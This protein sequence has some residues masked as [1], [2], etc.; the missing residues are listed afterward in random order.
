[1]AISNVGRVISASV[2]FLL[3]LP[4]MHF[5]KKDVNFARRPISE[6]CQLKYLSSLP[7]FIIYFKQMQK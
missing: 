4:L 5:Y 6:F 1:M 3:C 2:Q 7:L